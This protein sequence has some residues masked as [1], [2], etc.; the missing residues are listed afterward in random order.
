MDP[1]EP[2]RIRV[3][4]ETVARKI[5]A[6]EVIDRPLSVVR[7]LLDNAVDSGADS[8]ELFIEDGG[9]GRVRTVDNGSGM[10]RDDL[11]LCWHAHATSKIRSEEDLYRIRSLGFR[12]EALSSIASVSRLTIVSAERDGAA[13]K[14][15]VHGGR[16][17]GLEPFPGKKGTVVDAADL[18]YALPGR[19][20]FLKRGSAEA[21]LCRSMFVDK[22]LPFHEIAFRYF[23][24]GEMRLFLPKSD[25][26]GRIA[27]AYGEQLD[28]VK[29]HE[30]SGSGEGFTVRAVLAAPDVFRKDRRLIQVFVND[31]RISEFS[32]VQAVEYGFSE[33][34]PGGRFP[35]AFLFVNV[36]PGLADFNIH[37]AKREVRLRTL[38]EIHHRTVEIIRSFLRSYF[39]IS[40]GAGPG[41]SHSG[42][43][44]RLPLDEPSDRPGSDQP[45]DGPNRTGVR[46]TGGTGSGT[47]PVTWAELRDAGIPG[48]RAGTDSGQDDEAAGGEPPEV[49]DR[50][51]AGGRA[52]ARGKYRYLGQLFGLFLLVERDDRLFLIDQHA[53]HER[54]LY[55]GFRAVP[56]VRQ[57]LLVPYIL[58]LSR[59]EERLVERNLGEFS[60]FGVVLERQR[61]GVWCI[62]AVPE[63]YGGMID[64][65][66]SFIRG[67][68][69][70]VEDLEKRFYA[71]MACR[72]AV[73]DGDAVDSL[74]AAAIV[75]GA[76]ALPQPRCPHGRPVWVEISRGELFRLVER[77]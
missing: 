33:Y 69:G 71:T 2:G 18:F 30:I 11:G 5:A 68:R 10:N 20:Q 16:F 12:G 19:K 36:D 4:E 74:T 72:A 38:P 62:S 24:D 57:P 59:D 3:L 1:R 58:E 64:E 35:A 47:V 23:S 48:Y 13:H 55:D 54:M 32:L 65:I 53:A 39:G 44:P 56:P 40:R 70:A 50:E 21:A 75:E 22:A 41:F 37:P 45:A 66:A 76:F 7:E 60:R 63:P 61:E 25:L 8:I 26:S 17:I 77:S 28:G 46:F 27:A 52:A 49:R 67:D 15:T 73:K 31:R 51:T 14:L 34:M 6:G 9:I 42:S 43:G 29:L